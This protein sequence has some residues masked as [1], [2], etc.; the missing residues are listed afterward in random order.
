MVKSE[1][2]SGVRSGRHRRQ[3]R[4]RIVPL[5][6][7]IGVLAGTGLTGLIVVNGRDSDSGAA[8]G[9][10]CTRTVRTLHVSAAP[11]ITP[12]LAVIAKSMNSATCP[13]TVVSVEAA[14]PATVTEALEHPT[15]DRRAPDVWISDSSLWPTEVTHA[16]ADWRSIARSPIVLAVA[17]KIAHAH[18][19]GLT[20]RAVANAATTAHPIVLSALDPAHSATSVGILASLTASVRQNQ[21]TRGSLAALLRAADLDGHSEVLGSSTSRRDPAAVASTEQAV[22]A[23]NRLAAGEE[24][25]AVYP[26]APAP[27]LDYPYVVL[28][29]DNPADRAAAAFLAKISSPAG[30]AVLA[31]HGFRSPDGVA[32]R[33]LGQVRGVD[34]HAAGSG[35]SPTVGDASIVASAV[36]IVRKPSRLLAILDVSGSMASAVPGEPGQTR[37][38]IVRTA[39]AEGL[40]L[41]PDSSS[42]GLWRFSADLTPSTDYQQLE[43]VSPLSA[44]KRARLAKAV[45]NLDEV[46]N[47]GTGLYDTILAAVNSMR[48]D[49]DPTRVNSIVV[50][51]DGKDEA[52]ARHGISIRE[53]LTALEAQRRSSQP[54]QVVSIAYGPQSDADALRAISA[55]SGGILYLSPDPSDLPKIFANA[56]GHRLRD[57]RS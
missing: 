27:T 54:V 37:M 48:A 52:D 9:P 55:A 18:P 16:A 51:S 3:R 32:G 35:G 7:V 6:A 45:R 47:G 21:V 53:L 2:P 57:T 5:A 43:P 46:P 30:Q 38:S 20:L 8:V 33:E 44:D 42:V 34:P 56:I 50:L 26:S 17:S 49:Y 15:A 12:A 29:G 31:A 13:T 24:F 40:R 1:D 23:A 39:A 10:P 41:L 14:D 11:S 25:T 28:S 19:T 36:A 22:W 4:S